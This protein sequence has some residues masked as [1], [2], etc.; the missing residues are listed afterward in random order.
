MP[1]G[2]RKIVRKDS[3]AGSEGR[4]SSSL[5]FL[6]DLCY[7]KTMLKTERDIER[8][9]QKIV[10]L[11]FG[12]EYEKESEAGIFCHALKLNASDGKMRN[13]DVADMQGVFRII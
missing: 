2:S 6:G 7:S 9:I 13:T 10:V 4:K 11:A 12:Q 1:D 3:D 8:I 5:Y